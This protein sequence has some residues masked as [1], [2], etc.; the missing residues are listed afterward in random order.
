MKLPKI[1][2]GLIFIIILVGVPIGRSLYGYVMDQQEKSLIEALNQ[3]QR[4]AALE[5]ASILED[6]PVVTTSDVDKFQD[7][8]LITKHLASLETYRESA[9]TF[10]ERLK[11]IYRKRVIVV[12]GKD[13]ERD[14]KLAKAYNLTIELL[15]KG[16]VATN[17]CLDLQKSFYTF[18]LQHQQDFVIDQGRVFFNQQGLGLEYQRVLAA[19]EQCGDLVDKTKKEADEQLLRLKMEVQQQ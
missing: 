6:F 12:A 15:S 1:S 18:L 2:S 9:A 14:P 8:A 5:F 7:V 4:D 19:T 11:S 13:F 10:T 16:D 3:E 17:N